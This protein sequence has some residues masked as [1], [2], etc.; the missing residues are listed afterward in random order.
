MTHVVPHE[1]TI[2][3]RLEYFNELCVITM[4]YLLIFFLPGSFLAPQF[5]WDIG[6]VVMVLVGGVFVVNVAALIFLTVNRIIFKCKVRKA[7]L[8]IKKIRAR[9]SL[10]KPFDT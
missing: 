1:E 5:Q 2:H 6:T 9:R 10:I 8:A 4:Q 7:R 3:N